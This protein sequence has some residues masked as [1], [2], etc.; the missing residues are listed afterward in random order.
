MAFDEGTKRKLRRKGK[1]W[2]FFIR[3]L[4]DERFLDA[5]AVTPFALH[6]YVAIMSSVAQRRNRTIP[7][8]EME[9]LTWSG[10]LN[11]TMQ[12]LKKGME[13]LDRYLRQQCADTLS[14][15]WNRREK[16]ITVHDFDP[17]QDRYW[18]D[19]SKIESGEAA[20]YVDSD[21]EDSETSTGPENRLMGDQNGAAGGGNG[22]ARLQGIGGMKV[23]TP[24]GVRRVGG[25]GLGSAQNV[26]RNDVQNDGDLRTMCNTDNAHSAGTSLREDQRLETEDSENV[27]VEVVR[28]EAHPPTSENGDRTTTTT[29]TRKKKIESE[30][31]EPMKKDVS[32]HNVCRNDG[33]QSRLYFEEGGNWVEF[34]EH[35]F[36]T[37]PPTHMAR[38]KRAMPAFPV[39]EKLASIQEFAVIGERRV[40]EWMVQHRRASLGEALMGLTVSILREDWEKWVK[41]HAKQECI[42]TGEPDHQGICIDENGSC[43][44]ESVVCPSQA[45]DGTADRWDELIRSVGEMDQDERES[46]CSLSCVLAKRGSLQL[47]STNAGAA[48]TVGRRLAH[49]LRDAVMSVLGADENGKLMIE[50]EVR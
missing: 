24:W 34:V 5:L 41:D 21:D 50:I 4:D 7:W 37:I 17:H 45:A 39:D 14:M 31:E 2:K 13:A 6:A 19:I 29:T 3:F 28:P 44:R 33:K 8:R 25:G 10:K 35:W 30:I 12:Q 46:L 23:G 16:K 49:R 20:D 42:S 22:K 38:W 48:E 26:D 36:E 9:M 11:I 27:V 15:A 1:W 40:R 47:I 43:W 32:A 18:Q